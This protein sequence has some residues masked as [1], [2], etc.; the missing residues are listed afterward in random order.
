M[1]TILYMPKTEWTGIDG[2]NDGNI[3]TYKN[4]PMLSLTK[5][6]L[7]NSTDNAGKNEDG[8][9]KKVIVEFNDFVLNPSEDLAEYDFESIKSVFNDEKIF[10]DHYMENDKRAVEFFEKGLSIFN[11]NSIRCMRISDKNTTG[12]NGV[13]IDKSSPWN[14][15]VENKGVSD[16]LG[17]K[18]GSFGIGK[19]AA[20]ASS[21]VRIVFYNTVNEEG[22]SAF[23]GT[24]KLPS[25]RKGDLQYIG[26]GS[27]S[28]PNE[29]KDPV[30]ESVSL[31]PHYS[32]DGA[33]GMD[34]FILGFKDDISSEDLRDAI[35]TSSIDNFLYAFMDNKLE[36]KYG[37]LVIN[38]ETI[39]DLINQ[40]KLT[41]ENKEDGK[42]HLSNLTV[43]YYQTIKEYDEKLSIKILED[44]DVEIFV[45]LNPLGCRRAAIVRQSGMKVFDKDRLNA[46]IG[47]SAVVILRGD[48]VNEYFKKNLE[49]T[50]HTQWSLDRAK[51]P[52]EANRY[53]QTIFKAIKDTIVKLHEENME[54]SIDAEGVSEY[55]PYSYI[56][57]KK[58]TKRVDSLSNEVEE[59]TK[60]KK[61]KK[62][63]KD[64]RSTVEISLEMDEDGN[65]TERVINNNDEPSPFPGSVVPPNP[66]PVDP[67]IDSDGEE[68]K[69]EI[70]EDGK[71]KIKREIPSS[72]IK[73]HLIQR[74][75]NLY[76]LRFESNIEIAHGFVELMISSEQQAMAIDV[77]SATSENE[78]LIINKNMIR[79]VDV[80]PN[81]E[82]RILFSLKSEEDWALEVKANESKE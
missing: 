49:N 35:V 62:N 32:R 43:E 60:L 61:S 31:D 10:W 80:K 68:E 51:D 45:K 56:H 74:G 52:K 15:L 19:D 76:E 63:K 28:N 24:I 20:F 18:G 26:H 65:I 22:V 1:K 71:F 81:V 36:V 44:D 37:D 7:Q 79:L 42:S 39:D 54:A 48:A 9:Y 77:K 2:I 25:Y 64:I 47:F 14:N 72:E 70:K 11:S 27:F 57:G 46:R 23:K 6:E 38:S 4:N 17:N 16:K 34:K 67:R 82:K 13:G 58:D 5:E 73:A 12:L 66:D 59:K 40:Y 78:S 30:F 41:E 29:V 3:E 55:L 75:N 69:L 53:Q 33:I 50:E 21:Q 8:T